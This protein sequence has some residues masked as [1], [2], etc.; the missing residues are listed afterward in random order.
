MKNRAILQNQIL[1]NSV[2]G[3]VLLFALWMSVSRFE[4]FKEYSFYNQSRLLVA[5]EIKAI[6]EGLEV[7][8][9]YPYVILDLEGK[10]IHGDNKFNLIANDYVNLKEIV[11]FDKS[12]YQQNQEDIKVSFV[13]E[14]NKKVE[15][16]VLF[17]IPRVDAIE[18][19]E[20][21]ILCYIFVPILIAVIVTILLLI[22]RAFYLK[23]HILDP[24]REISE[25]AQ[26]IILGNY[27]IPVVKVQGSRIMS[28][29]VDELTYGFELMRDKLKE[30]IIR[31]DQLKRSQKEL[32]SCISHDL[33]TPISTIKAYS[34][35]LRDGMA[36]T[37]EKQMKYYNI[38]VNKSEV[39]NHMIS[40]L[41]E[42]SNAELN[43]LKIIKKE[44]YFIEYIEK[45]TKE[46]KELV[47][48]QGFSFEFEN[49][50]PNILV[51]MDKNRI[52]QVIANL[53]DNSMKY[54]NPKDG[55][56]IIDTYYDSN[57]HVV[58]IT[59]KDNGNGIS[60]EDIPY[61]LDKFYRAE[62]SRN[63]GI[64][65]SGLGLSI[66]K[67]IIEQHGGTISCKSKVGIGTEFKFSIKLQS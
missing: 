50:V 45:I 14:R 26:A 22:L 49:K 46:M 62:K 21:E 58:I 51:S 19:S 44:Q 11:Q 55:I 47:E 2:I 17:L 52:T 54:T 23:R 18:K 64:P 41:L 31:E 60:T 42:H 12:F 35:G 5:E 43:E 8:G 24:M 10:V 65:G 40:D 3:V 63:M 37:P 32:I 39:L 28:N 1:I 15:G 56:I 38:I 29:E 7:A 53:I 25:S 6:E 16:F 4:N 30:K 66:C 27:D 33:K 61:V 13:L 36:N 9:K 67:Y 48:H 34:E 59:V 57:D 20:E